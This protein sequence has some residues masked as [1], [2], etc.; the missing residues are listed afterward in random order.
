MNLICKATMV[1]AVSLLRSSD[2]DAADAVRLLTTTYTTESTVAQNI[3]EECGLPALVSSAV[4]NGARKRGIE[5]VTLES[6]SELPVLHIE[7]VDAMSA[8]SAG[9]GGHNKYVTL[10][11]E[12]QVDGR[13]PVRFEAHRRSGGGAWGWM[14]SACSVFSRITSSLGSDIAGWLANPTDG[15]QLGDPI[16]RPR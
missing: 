13:D 2:V 11:G 3:R 9:P 7:I 6:A 15:A 8:R 5:V 10:R 1:A 12:L 14:K 16:A 4:V